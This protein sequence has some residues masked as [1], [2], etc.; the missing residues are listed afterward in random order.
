MPMPLVE[1]QIAIGEGFDHPQRHFDL[2]GDHGRFHRRLQQFKVIGPEVR[3]PHRA[4][5]ARRH[6][7]IER[8]AGFMVVHERIRPVDQQQV[9]MV[10]RHV[11]QR[12]F[13]RLFDM[14]PAG[15][16][17]FDRCVFVPSHGG[18]DIALG[19]DL[20]L[21]AQAGVSLQRFAQDRLG[22]IAAI[23][24]GLIKSSDALVEA[25]V[26]LGLDVRHGCVGII[27]QPPHAI[28]D[29]G[30]FEGIG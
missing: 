28:D 4:N 15:V 17:I 25:G 2:I 9:D 22:D 21:G 18:D 6:Q 14:R 27:T 19:H 13:H 12:V 23:D 20:H 8:A 26:D 30:H 1:G 10:N 7:S 3:D 29:A 11:P 5:L 24:V 16:V